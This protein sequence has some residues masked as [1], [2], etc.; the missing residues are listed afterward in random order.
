MEGMCQRHCSG[1]GVHTHTHTHHPLRVS[2]YLRCLHITSGGHAALPVPRSPP[3]SLARQSPRRWTTP[4]PTPTHPGPERWDRCRG[5][6]VEGRA[7]EEEDHEG[8]EIELLKLREE[9]LHVVVL[10]LE[11]RRGND[12]VEERP[13]DE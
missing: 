9:D 10:A 4:C 13:H 3:D 12:D 11:E 8:Q 6:W 7:R 1:G 5:S 2:H